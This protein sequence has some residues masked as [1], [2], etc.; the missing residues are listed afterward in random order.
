M[1]VE[2]FDEVS[3]L[4]FLEARGYQKIAKIGPD[5][6]FSNIPEMCAPSELKNC[7]E[8]AANMLVEDGMKTSRRRV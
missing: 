2:T 7:F 3:A 5:T 8:I 6:F 1:Q 4:E